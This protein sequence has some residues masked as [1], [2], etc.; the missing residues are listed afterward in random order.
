[1]TALHITSCPPFLT[2]CTLQPL[3]QHP[4]IY[5]LD[6]HY[7]ADHFS[8]SLFSTLAI[9]TPAHLQRAVKK[10]RAEYLASRYS[11]QQALASW[12]IPS[13]LLGNAPDRTPVWPQGINGSLSH[14]HQ[15]VTALLTRRQDRLLGVDCERIMTGQ[16]AS[17]THSMLIT[18]EEKSLLQQCSVPFA[19]A[20]TVVFSLKES[21]YKAIYPQVQQFMDFHAAEVIACSADLQQIRLRLTQA[22]S[23]KMG[24]GREFDGEAVLQPDQ[25]VTWIIGPQ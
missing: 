12:G 19:T 5:L 20:L 13:F 9:P 22:C 7:N 23:R 3:V 18:A 15:Q 25:V 17:E 1:M 24:A 4:D 16:V 14:T 2:H 10:R 8:E 11:V 21:L 6:A